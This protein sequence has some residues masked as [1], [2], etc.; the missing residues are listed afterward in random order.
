[1]KKYIVGS[2]LLILAMVLVACG[3]KDE[4]DEATGEENPLAPSVDISDEEKVDDDKVVAVVNG[5]E[6][7]GGVYNLV[8]AQLKLQSAQL[9]D[10]TDNEEMKDL[11]MESVIDREIV[12]Q[13]AKEEGI[14]IT[15][16][17][18]DKEF[19]TLKEENSEALDTL[20]EQYQITE[21]GFKEQLRFELIMDEFLSETID[22][23]ISDDDVKEFY[24][25]AKEEAEEGDSEGE[26]PEFDEVKDQIKESMEQEEMTLA[27]QDKVD[28]VKET[29]EIERKI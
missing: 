24:D 26:I 7:K 6:V 14:E 1:M 18:A 19:K 2:L 15:E 5:N 11:T 13:E 29:A 4:E 16:E 25:E 10:E 22:V 9:G 3:D 17:E 20:L 8:Y 27:L 12:I 28:E 23:D 21:D